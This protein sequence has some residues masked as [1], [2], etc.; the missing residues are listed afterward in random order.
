[1]RERGSNAARQPKKGGGG[2]PIGRDSV[3]KTRLRLLI[4][5]AIGRAWACL[6]AILSPDWSSRFGRRA[7]ADAQDTKKARFLIKGIGLRALCVAS[8]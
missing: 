2:L 4:L 8:S 7:E 6:V 5:V 1:M 3:A